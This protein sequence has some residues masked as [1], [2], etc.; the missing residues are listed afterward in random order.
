MDRREV[1]PPKI[2]ENNDKNENIDSDDTEVVI[3]I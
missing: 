3:S 1:K 2:M